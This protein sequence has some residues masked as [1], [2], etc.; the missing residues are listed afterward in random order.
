[1]G[2]IVVKLRNVIKQMVS[3]L[4]SRLAWS[5]TVITG[6]TLEISGW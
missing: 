6:C 4:Q 2:K 3:E 1:M 5:Q